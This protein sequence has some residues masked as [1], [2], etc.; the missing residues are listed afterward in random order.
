M[1][2]KVKQWIIN[3]KMEGTCEETG[4]QINIGDQVLYLPP[5]KNIC[6]GRVF[7]QVS[8]EYKRWEDDVYTGWKTKN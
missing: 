1:D 4:K 8:E 3:A 2:L 5:V 7:C 6:G